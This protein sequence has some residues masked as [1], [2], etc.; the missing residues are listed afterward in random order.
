MSDKR[1][2]AAAFGADLAAELQS[3]TLAEFRLTEA[4][5]ETDAQL[6]RELL[7]PHSNAEWSRCTTEMLDVSRV[8][9]VETRVA[10]EPPQGTV[11]GER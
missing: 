1:S 4:R 9:A 10:A 11:A 2:A 5:Y 6:G 8:P 3:V 7:F